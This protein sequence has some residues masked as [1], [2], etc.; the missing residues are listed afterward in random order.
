MSR[1]VINPTS[2]PREVL[3]KWLGEEIIAVGE[4]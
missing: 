2:L 3:S 1:S 4:M